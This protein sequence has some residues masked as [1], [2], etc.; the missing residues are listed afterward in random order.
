L[1]VKIREEQTKKA[2][3]LEITERLAET[4]RG[5][6]IQE[7][8]LRDAMERIAE[9]SPEKRISKQ[10]FFLKYSVVTDKQI[11]ELKNKLETLET[12]QREKT[13]EL[14]R[15]RRFREGLERLRAEAK[16]RFIE[17]EEKLE[18]KELD[19]IA[20]ICFLR[21]RTAVCNRGTIR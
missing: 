18:Q 12:Q 2:E 15:I 11:Q 17:K 10:E 6:F 14:L 4:R 21:R 16:R 9:E 19:E 3:L 5:L 13:T 20:G 7:R 8:I 1:D